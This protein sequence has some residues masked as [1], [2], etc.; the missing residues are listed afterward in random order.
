MNQKLP[1]WVPWLE[2]QL[3]APWFD[4]LKVFKTRIQSYDNLVLKDPETQEDENQDKNQHHDKDQDKN[5]HRDK[6]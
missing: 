3:L 6:K 5:W 2:I 1:V 4:M